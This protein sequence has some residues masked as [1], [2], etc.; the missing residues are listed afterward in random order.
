MRNRQAG[1]ARN[2]D[3]EYKMKTLYSTR[4]LV[5]PS[6]VV[7]INPGSCAPREISHRLQKLDHEIEHTI[8]IRHIQL[9]L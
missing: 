8:Y 5:N 4:T 9:R 3:L 1:P 7:Y 2:I 6:L